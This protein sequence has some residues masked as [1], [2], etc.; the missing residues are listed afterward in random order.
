MAREYA[1]DRAAMAASDRLQAHGPPVRPRPGI[2]DSQL[3]G[4]RELPRTRLRDR[5]SRQT[6]A[7]IRALLRAGLAPA[8]TGRGHR[9]RRTAHRTGDFPRRLAGEKARDHLALGARS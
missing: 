3:L 4:R 2:E 7:A 8:I 9:R 1:R 6:P 5:P